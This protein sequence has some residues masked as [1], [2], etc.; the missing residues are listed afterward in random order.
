MVPSKLTVDLIL[1]TLDEV[2]KTNKVI[3]FNFFKEYK[4]RKSYWM[5]S[6]GIWNKE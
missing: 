6:Q 2:T 4:N 1:K 3:D 5:V